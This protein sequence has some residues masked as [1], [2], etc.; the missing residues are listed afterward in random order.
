V[1]SSELPDPIYISAER[2]GFRE[3][4]Y[5]RLYLH[6][7][8]LESVSCG[9]NMSF[10]LRYAG[11]DGEECPHNSLC[12]NSLDSINRPYSLVLTRVYLDI[13]RVVYNRRHR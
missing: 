7:P 3:S 1:V 4:V 10:R 11:R 8:S 12:S 6:G 2:I 5:V 13:R 9:G